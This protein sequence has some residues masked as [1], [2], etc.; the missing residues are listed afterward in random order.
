MECSCRYLTNMD[1]NPLSAFFTLIVMVE[2]GLV[3]FIISL[4]EHQ[5]ERRIETKRK[6][7]KGK[8]V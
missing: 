5:L 4:V 3:L 8:Y 2:V 6:T 7:V 1:N